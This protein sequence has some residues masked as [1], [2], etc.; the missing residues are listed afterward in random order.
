M[1]DLKRP[2]STPATHNGNGLKKEPGTDC[3]NRLKREQLDLAVL[4]AQYAGVAYWLSHYVTGDSK[5]AEDVLQK[6]FL[7]VQSDFTDLKQSEPVAM[8]LARIAINESFNKLRNRNAS[9]LLWLSI[10]A[11][12]DGAFVPQEVVEWSDR[13]D[14]GYAREALCGIV[15]EGVQG[16]TPFSRVVFLLVDVARLRP[17]DIADL[18]HVPVPRVKSHLLRSRLQLREHLNKYFKSSLKEKTETA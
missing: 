18:F 2:G 17:E 10:E 14:R 13:A 6:T 16:L 8:R 7:T 15:H 12:V 3:G 4:V 9:K 11:E 5:D 1:C